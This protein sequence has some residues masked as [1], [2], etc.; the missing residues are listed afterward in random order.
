MAHYGLGYMKGGHKVNPCE[1]YP[2]HMTRH[3]Y[4]ED[5]ATSGPLTLS[6]VPR[7]PGLVTLLASP[8]TSSPRAPSAR[9][10]SSASSHP[11]GWPLREATERSMS[12]ESSPS[13]STVVPPTPP[14]ST[15]T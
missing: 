12:T 2:F 15:S 6:L 1:K 7:E 5:G 14:T 8:S 4:G 10:R 11:T 3:W 9:A 13:R